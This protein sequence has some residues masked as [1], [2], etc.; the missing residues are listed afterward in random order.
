MVTAYGLTIT[1]PESRDR[2]QRI[3]AAGSWGQAEL[4]GNQY[5]YYRSKAHATALRFANQKIV[6]FWLKRYLSSVH[7]TSHVEIET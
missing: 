2:R 1:F 4:L 6:L 5:T 7:G 3:L